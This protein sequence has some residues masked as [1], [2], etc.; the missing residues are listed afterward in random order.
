[1]AL[2]TTFSF[3]EVN[4]LLANIDKPDPKVF[5]FVEQLEI[6]T[7]IPK[8]FDG[9]QGEE[10]TFAKIY[11][12]IDEENLYLKVVYFTDSYGEGEFL[13]SVQF[14]SAR[15]KSINVYVQI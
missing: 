14:V 15:E 2:K 7:P 13:R 12:V 8:N 4:T 1:M 3:K 5:R 9:L 10:N 6:D 11:R